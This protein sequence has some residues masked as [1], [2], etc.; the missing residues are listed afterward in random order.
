MVEKY[1]I[2]SNLVIF[3]RSLN[4]VPQYFE[5][6]KIILK[7]CLLIS[8]LVKTNLILF[9][10]LNPNTLYYEFLYW[11]FVQQHQ[12]LILWRNYFFKNPKSA[13]KSL[14]R[15]KKFRIFLLQLSHLKY[16]NRSKLFIWLKELEAVT[17]KVDLC[18]M[19][20]TILNYKIFVISDHRV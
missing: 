16:R 17:K 14:W 6:L 18:H 4:F 19:F 8:T 1:Q 12:F 10:F 13:L 9:N 15:G 7:S 11:C 5:Y 2:P 20:M 3:V